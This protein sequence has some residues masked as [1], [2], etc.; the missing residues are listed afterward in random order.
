MAAKYHLSY[1]FVIF[2]VE[3]DVYVMIP[4]TSDAKTVQI[5]TT[6]R[7]AF[8]RGW[9]LA[10]DKAQFRGRQIV[11]A[12]FLRH[13]GRWWIWCME[14]NGRRLRLFSAR[15]LIADDWEEA[16]RP[17]AAPA[18]PRWPRPPE[19]VRPPPQPSN[20]KHTFLPPLSRSLAL[21][22]QH[23][24]SPVATRDKRWTRPGGRPFVY[25]GLVFHWVQDNSRHYGNGLHL[26]RANLTRSVYTQHL[27]RSL[28]PPD[29]VD[30]GGPLPRFASHRHHHVDVQSVGP[31][32]FYALYDGDSRHAILL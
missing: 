15:D 21:P 19:T 14:L 5:F 1:P 12:S 16:R 18:R 3:R 22:A 31:G 10:A 17:A 9:T 7:D 27:V 2:D 13:L 11:D 30:G 24:A 29:R 20:S 4:E 28:I 26:F 25:H 6:T 23:P 8:P 32:D